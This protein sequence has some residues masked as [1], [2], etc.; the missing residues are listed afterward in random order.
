MECNHPTN[1]EAWEPCVCLLTAVSAYQFSDVPDVIVIVGGEV[2]FWIIFHV[3]L[4]PGVHGDVLDAGDL[5][6]RQVHLVQ[7][8]APPGGSI[9]GNKVHEVFKHTEKAPTGLKAP[10]SLSYLRNSMTLC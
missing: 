10:L 3:E 6:V 1:S 9:P 2:V 7:V 8:E 4:G 5:T